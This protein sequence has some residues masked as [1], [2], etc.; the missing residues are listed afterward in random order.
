MNGFIVHLHI[1]VVFC[2]TKPDIDLKMYAENKCRFAPTS[3]F[4][5]HHGLYFANF[6]IFF[7]L[8][9]FDCFP[10]AKPFIDVSGINLRRL[11]NENLQGT[12]RNLKNRTGPICGFL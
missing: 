12:N 5:P 10:R 9:A 6:A 7:R 1:E 11:P 4:L 8:S 2:G 3:F